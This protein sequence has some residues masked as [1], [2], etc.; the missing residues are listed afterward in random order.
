MTRNDR[1]GQGIP[2]WPEQKRLVLLLSIILAGILLARGMGVGGHRPRPDMSV[3]EEALPAPTAQA[4]EQTDLP[5]AQDIAAPRDSHAEP[6]ARKASRRN[7]ARVPVSFK[8]SARPGTEKAYYLDFMNLFRNDPK[9]YREE[10]DSIL[11]G[12]GPLPEKV[13]ALRASYDARIDPDMTAFLRVLEDSR[14]EPELRSFAA[15]Y[16]SKKSKINPQVQSVQN[17]DEE[18]QSED[19]SPDETPGTGP[20]E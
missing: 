1:A 13:A 15:R 18:S 7:S 6:T 3:A 10:I 19:V 14:A 20:S 8:P 9:L 11:F 2:L 5:L 17:Q 16:L 12:T 4:A